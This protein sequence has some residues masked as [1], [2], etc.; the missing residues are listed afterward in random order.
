MERILAIVSVDNRLRA[1]T[2]GIQSIGTGMDRKG[3][4]LEKYP[5]LDAKGSS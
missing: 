4:R 2:G 3:V 5:V 1:G